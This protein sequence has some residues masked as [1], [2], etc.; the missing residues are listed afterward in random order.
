MR[1]GDRPQ[2]HRV[3]RGEAEV[4]HARA[5]SVFLCRRV[6]LQVAER[7][8]R[9]DVSMRRA[10]AHADRARQ[11]GDAEQRYLA[12][13]RTEDAQPALERPGVRA[14]ANWAFH[15]HVLLSGTPS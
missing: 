4:E 14:V 2:L 8:E 6:L 7:G 9:R 11:L 5:E 10:S 1:R 15:T 13:E 12:A 3:D